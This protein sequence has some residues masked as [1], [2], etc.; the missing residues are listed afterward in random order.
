MAKG[1][2]NKEIGAKLHLALPTVKDHVQSIMVT[3]QARNRTQ[4]VAL[5]IT[6]GLVQMDIHEVKLSN[7]IRAQY[8]PER[9]QFFVPYFGWL[10]GEAVEVMQN[11]RKTSDPEQNVLKAIT[12]TVR[13]DSSDSTQAL[14]CDRRHKYYRILPTVKL[15]PGCLVDLTVTK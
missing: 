6:R 3:L 9:D 14:W 8:Y 11:T 10:D 1:Y 15:C 5:G 12:H 7:G 13:P 2:E 4:A